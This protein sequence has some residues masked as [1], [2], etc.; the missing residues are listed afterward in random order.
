MYAK[1]K[2][3]QDERKTSQKNKTKLHLRNWAY[4]RLVCQL[5]LQGVNKQYGIE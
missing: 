3:N 2:Q 1:K 4:L 5:L